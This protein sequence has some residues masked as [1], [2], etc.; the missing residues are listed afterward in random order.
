M[1]V[2]APLT[3]ATSWKLPSKGATVR[4]LTGRRRV[5]RGDGRPARRM[6]FRR[7]RRTT[8]HVFGRVV[9][10]RFDAAALT[11]ASAATG[12]AAQL[13]QDP[14]VL[15]QLP[16]WHRRRAWRCA[17]STGSTLARIARVTAETF[18]IPVRDNAS[19]EPA[20]SSPRVNRSR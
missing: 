2:A 8:S 15:P 17:T 14:C 13:F 11:A 20:T 19:R 16:E 5:E 1:N 12:C 9:S 7:L 6:R 3:L 4:D 18:A 10:E